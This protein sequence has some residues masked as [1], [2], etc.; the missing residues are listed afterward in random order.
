[1]K[2][3]AFELAAIAEVFSNVVRQSLREQPTHLKTFLSCGVVQLLASFQ[4][5]KIAVLEELVRCC[6]VWLL[7]RMDGHLR[8]GSCC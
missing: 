6:I 4:S 8:C 3:S 7:Y 2:D 1:M 5:R